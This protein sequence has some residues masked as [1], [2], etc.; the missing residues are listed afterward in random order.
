MFVKGNLLII[1][2]GPSGAGKSSITSKLL[3]SS[4]NLDFS[5]SYTTREKRINEHESNDYIY[6][7]K[8]KFEELIETNSFLEYEIVHGNYYGTPIQ[9]IK[10]AMGFNHSV[11]LDV[12]VKGASTIINTNHFD[13]V[14]F[15][16]RPPSIE[17]LY[18]RL[19]NRGDMKDQ[20]IDKRVAEAKNE[21][22]KS[23]YFDHLIVNENFEDCFNEIKRIIVGL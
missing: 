9:P 18:Q 23:K 21:I 12:D 2:S 22:I 11:L 6:V 13:C 20:E 19:V 4:K 8:E 16:I 5:V 7:S 10:E 15:F 14:S 3:S 1:I 17:D